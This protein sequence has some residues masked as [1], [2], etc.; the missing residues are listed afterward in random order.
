MR[1]IEPGDDPSVNCLLYPFGYYILLCYEN[2]HRNPPPPD[3]DCRKSD[4]LAYAS[5]TIRRRKRPKPVKPMCEFRLLSKVEIAIRIIRQQLPSTG[6]AK[7]TS[8][9]PL[10]PPSAEKCCQVVVHNKTAI[11]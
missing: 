10:S 11:Q 5:Q 9:R 6:G 1:S 2:Q 7:R 8:T 3:G 4:P